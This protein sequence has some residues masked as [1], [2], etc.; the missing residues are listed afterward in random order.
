MYS[1]YRFVNMGTVSGVNMLC[2]CHWIFPSLMYLCYNQVKRDGIG[3]LYS[4]IVEIPPKVLC[5][6]ST[7]ITE[8]TEKEMNKGIRLWTHF[9]NISFSK[10]QNKFDSHQSCSVAFK[11]AKVQNNIRLNILWEA[12]TDAGTYHTPKGPWDSSAQFILSRQF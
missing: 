6:L 8:V 4:E 10:F 11:S 3:N 1:G 5:T 9:Q 7:E 2:Q 12:F